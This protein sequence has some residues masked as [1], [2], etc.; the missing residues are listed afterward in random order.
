MGIVE[1]VDYYI[2]SSNP[3]LLRLIDFSAEGLF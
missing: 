1:V 2:K 3:E